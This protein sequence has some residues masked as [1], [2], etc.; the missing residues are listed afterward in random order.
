MSTA[1][2][3][4]DDGFAGR[5]DDFYEMLIEAHRGLDQ[6]QSI[7]LNVRCLLLL[8]NHVGELEIIRQ[9]LAAARNSLTL[10]SEQDTP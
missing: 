1:V 4:R 6:E 2:L 5:G 8:A 9:A 10:P 3:R 7:A